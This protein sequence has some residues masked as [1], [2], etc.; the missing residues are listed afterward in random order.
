MKPYIRPWI[1]VL[2]CVWMPLAVTLVTERTYAQDASLVVFE[3]PLTGVFDG[4]TLRK[5][6][7]LGTLDGNALQLLVTFDGLR[8]PWGQIDLYHGDPSNG[9]TPF[10]NL[11]LLIYYP[12][13]LGGGV[14][15]TVTLTQEQVQALHKGFFY[16]RVSMATALPDD[17]LTGQLQ[18][19]SLSEPTLMASRLSH[20]SQGYPVAR[21]SLQAFMTGDALRVVGFFNALSSDW[22]RI[23]LYRGRHGAEGTAVAMIYRPPGTAVF[24]AGFDQTFPVENGWAEDFRDGLFYVEVDASRASDKLRGRLLSTTNQAPNASAI[25]SPTDGETIVIGGT[26]GGGAEDPDVY[27]G[28]ITLAPV[29]DPDGNA[30]AYLWQAS[31]RPG[32]G[33]IETVTFDLG[34]DSTRIPLTVAYAAALF[35]TL[36][37]RQPGNILLDTPVE[38]YHRVVTTDGSHYTV[39]E[40]VKTTFIRGKVTANEPAHVLPGA[41]ALQGNYPNPFN[42]STTITFDLASHAEVALEVFDVMG[43]RVL[44]L[45][46]RPMAAGKGQRIEVDA[47]ALAS[48]TYLYRVVV[49][50][51]SAVLMDSGHMTLLR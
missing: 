30:V 25:T 43:R 4:Q 35:D 32:F 38:V 13:A 1:P 48:G 15:D 6:T 49:R 2:L 51:P 3:A 46:P 47:S 27:L 37:G 41:L 14:N 12:E 34:V 9:G 23:T 19:L 10:K 45:S 20:I 29:D 22:Q 50:T 28:T 5:G 33:S 40:A 21:G 7:A 18:G 8:I 24:F 36:S 17:A 11:A 44:A 26:G 42:P 39:G 16:I 31:L